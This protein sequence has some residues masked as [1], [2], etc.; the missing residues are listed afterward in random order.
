MAVKDAL[1]LADATPGSAPLSAG[2][3]APG[4][5]QRETSA[6]SRSATETLNGAV[7]AQRPSTLDSMLTTAS[8]GPMS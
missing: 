5:I 1:L 6:G 7:A 8:A 4:Y 2:W 3:A